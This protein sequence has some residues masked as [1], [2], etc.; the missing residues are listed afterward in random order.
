[1]IRALLLVT[2]ATGCATMADVAYLI[3]GPSSRGAA[4]ATAHG[5]GR[6]D[7]HREIAIAPRE[8]IVCRD[9]ETPYVTTTTVAT[10]ARHPNSYKAVM[11]VFTALEGGITAATVAGIELQCAT[12]PQDCVENRDRL[13]LYAIPLFAD[14]L[15]GVYR[16]FTIHNAIVR[17]SRVSWQGDQ[18]PVQGTTLASSCPPGTEVPLYAET[19]QLIVHVGERGR[20]VEAE[21][22]LVL[23]FVMTHPQFSVGGGFRLDAAGVADLVAFARVKL[24]PPPVAAAPATT[25]TPPTTTVEVPSQLCIETPLAAACVRAAPPPPPPPPDPR[26]RD[27]R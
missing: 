11:Q 7:H 14:I 17:E 9:I 3:G 10:D 1:M 15:W 16:S 18:T 23:R 4:S 26:I 20:V 21:A 2:L 19:E 8:G 22:E 25:T 13:Y 5:T 27:H 12:T 24:A 6:I